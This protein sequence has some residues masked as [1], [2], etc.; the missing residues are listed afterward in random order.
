M[1]PELVELREGVV[2]A[3]TKYNLSRNIVSALDHQKDLLVQLSAN[4]RAE[5]KLHEL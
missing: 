2:D 3:D 4:K 5:M 1:V